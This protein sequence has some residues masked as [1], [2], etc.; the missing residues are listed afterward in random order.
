MINRQTKGMRATTLQ[1]AAP[2]IERHQLGKTV[3]GAGP[4]DRD[5][6]I[7]ICEQF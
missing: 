4:N 2:G 7:F 6:F 3:C 5:L 1:A